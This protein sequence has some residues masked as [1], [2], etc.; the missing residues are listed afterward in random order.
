MRR[1][2][3]FFPLS[4]AKGRQTR[5]R[6]DLAIRDH[7][8]FGHFGDQGRGGD[9]VDARDRLQSD[10]RP[11]EGQV[12]SHDPLYLL[13]VRGDLT[14]QIRCAIVGHEVEHAVDPLPLPGLVL[15]LQPL[16]GRDELGPQ[17]DMGPQFAENGQRQ[18][19]PRVGASLQEFGD[20][21]RVDR[22]VLG[23]EP[24]GDREGLD[25]R[26]RQLAGR[27][28]LLGQDGPQGSLAAAGGLEADDRVHFASH[29]R[30]LGV[31]FPVVRQTRFP[32][33]GQN[34]VAKISSTG[35]GTCSLSPR[36]KRY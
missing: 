33:V 34:V 28:L 5:Q 10:R 9:E 32:A 13:V 23:A 11:V 29:F 12:G 7:P 30:D 14:F 35:R 27:D 18:L 2:P 6:G 22:V 8:E 20:H 31:A 17:G 36:D 25:L 15:V 19:A 16:Q 21:L 26:R 3:F 24:H 1:L 4:R